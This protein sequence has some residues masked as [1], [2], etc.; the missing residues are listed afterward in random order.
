MK[1]LFI[2]GLA[3][4]ILSLASVSATG[5]DEP[6]PEPGAEAKPIKLRWDFVKGEERK[7]RMVQTM[8]QKMDFGRGTTET[9]N[10]NTIDWTD[11]CVGFAEEDAVILEYTYDRIALKVESDAINV[12]YDSA[13]PD[14]A[15]LEKLTQLKGTAQLAG[16]KFTYEVTPELKVQNLKGWDKLRDQVLEEFDP[17]MREQ[18][19]PSFSDE[20]RIAQLET[21]LR[22]IPKKKVKP[23]DEWED[24]TTEPAGTVGS[25][26]V[27][28]TYTLDSVEETDEGTFA[29]VSTKGVG[30]FEK[31][32][33]GQFKDWKVTMDDFEYAGTFRFDTERGCGVKQS[34]T[35]KFKMELVTD[36]MT[37]TQSVEVELSV[38]LLREKEDEA[39][40]S[41]PK[42]EQVPEEGS[43]D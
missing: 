18:L 13:D 36:T 1:K 3:G 23:G 42:D 10:V 19:E 32:E 43:K 37:M 14:P 39:K 8:K 22:A 16:K 20:T 9:L 25:L 29:V 12:D 38:E 41:K 5:Q 2:S 11:R 28:L 24:T 35:S 31:F 33:A 26:T 40:P 21:S 30:K 6:K 17:V 4:C 15:E 7:F 34:T 27:D